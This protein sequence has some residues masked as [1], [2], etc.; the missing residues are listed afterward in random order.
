M[1]GAAE[2][3]LTVAWIPK[4]RRRANAAAA[5]S[6]EMNHRGVEHG[7][8]IGQGSHHRF[9]SSLPRLLW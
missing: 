8:G 7:V 4:I 2:K 6:C 9:G 5:S 3:K 1:P